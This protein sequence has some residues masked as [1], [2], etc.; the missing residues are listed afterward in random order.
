MIK[1]VDRYIGRATLL[2]ILAV[3]VGL[4][5][6]MLM[7]SLLDELRSIRGGYGIDDVF[8]FVALTTPSAFNAACRSFNAWV[9]KAESSSSRT[10]RVVLRTRSW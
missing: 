1:R 10:L 7:F 2:G 8:W 4:T 5:L 6:L 9:V 3:W